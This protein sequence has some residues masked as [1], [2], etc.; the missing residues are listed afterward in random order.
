MGTP[1]S[2]GAATAKSPTDDEGALEEG[3]NQMDAVTII[4]PGQLTRQEWATRLN[5][6][7]DRIRE[8]AKWLQLSGPPVCSSDKIPMKLQTAAETEQPCEREAA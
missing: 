1:C 4:K 5:D 3:V 6:Q 8:S 7:W 2:I